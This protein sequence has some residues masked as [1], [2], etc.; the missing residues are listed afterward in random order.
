M[1]KAIVE[2]PKKFLGEAKELSEKENWDQSEANAKP[3]E[4]PPA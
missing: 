2:Q 1:P 3:E 4:N